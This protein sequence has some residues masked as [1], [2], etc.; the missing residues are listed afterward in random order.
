MHCHQPSG[1]GRGWFDARSTTPLADAGILDGPVSDPLGL[2]GGRVVVPSAPERS[3][4]LERL[5]RSDERRMPPLAVSHHDEAAAK[6]IEEW[7]RSLP[8]MPE[9]PP[10]G[11]EAHY[12]SG[13]NFEK[14]VCKRLDPTIDFEW[15]GESPAPGLTDSLYS[16]RWTGTLEIPEGGEWT[17]T[18]AV[19][20]GG[21]LYLD[22]TK[23]ID[24]WIDQGVTEYSWKIT[25]EKGARVPIQV[26]F[27]QRYGGSVA[28][29]YW[30]GPGQPK[31][32]IS[33]R[34]LTPPSR[35]RWY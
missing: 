17:I 32:I 19:D 15:T 9:H 27:Y 2:Q 22:G 8:K 4:L 24:K 34:R 31:A 18:I 26:E 11:L 13:C 35:K 33:P 12:F 30:E 5:K 23:V 3:L 16:V 20:D 25:K 7:I 21:R 14:L 1:S 28:R 6:M 10:T 29:L